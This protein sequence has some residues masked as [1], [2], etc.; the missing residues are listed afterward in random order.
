MPLL[1]D[2][3]IEL[4]A[5]EAHVDKRDICRVDG[6]VIQVQIF[7]GTGYCCD[8]HRK[9]IQGDDPSAYPFNG[10]PSTGAT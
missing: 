10:N 5:T 8:K 2:E 4:I 7:K 6:N 1:S 3:E 9:V